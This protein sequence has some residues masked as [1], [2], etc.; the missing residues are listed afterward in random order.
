MPDAE[1]VVDFGKS[2][3]A[4]AFQ[5]AGGAV[6]GWG[7]AVCLMQADQHSRCRSLDVPGSSMPRN[8]E[9]IK[10]ARKDMEFK[11]VHSLLPSM[12]ASVRGNV[13]ALG[14]C[15]PRVCFRSV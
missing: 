14:W 15:F 6:K 13:A 5:V 9:T 11:M 12:R 10:V 3:Q 8:L 2:F 4:A 1:S 7:K